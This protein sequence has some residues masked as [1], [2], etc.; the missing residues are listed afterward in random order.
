MRH[1]ISDQ[2]LPLALN[3]SLVLNQT[4]LYDT[5]FSGSELHPKPVLVC[6]IL[7]PIFPAHRSFPWANAMAAGMLYY[8][9]R[10]ELWHFLQILSNRCAW[11]P[12]R[13][14]ANASKGL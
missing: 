4:D 7:Y 14:S 10:G 3:L 11:N 2:G 8:L 5:T 12:R 9:S 13:Q 1:V 6:E